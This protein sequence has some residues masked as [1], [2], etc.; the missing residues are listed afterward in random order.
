MTNL[1]PESTHHGSHANPDLCE[2]STHAPGLMGG[3]FFF[4]HTSIW[5]FFFQPD[6]RQKA[7]R[8]VIL[9][10]GKQ[11]SY[12]SPHLRQDELAVM[13]LHKCAEESD[14]LLF[15]NLTG[16]EPEEEVTLKNKNNNG[17]QSISE[18]KKTQAGRY[19]KEEKIWSLN[20]TSAPSVLL[21]FQPR[22]FFKKNA[23]PWG[24]GLAWRPCQ[25]WGHV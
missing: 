22:D 7:F 19:L 3:C 17:T 6:Y 24:S 4:K 16:Q 23:S 18:E 8:G 10:S 20:T 15:S 21:S 25:G 11:F 9:S 5:A 13:S 1:V 14:E 2:D 12:R